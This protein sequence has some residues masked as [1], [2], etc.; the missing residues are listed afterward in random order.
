MTSILS[1]LIYLILAPIA[2]G[3]LDGADRII[4]ARMQ[5]SPSS[6]LL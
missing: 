1:V 6:A 5:G 3:L 4:S 2:G